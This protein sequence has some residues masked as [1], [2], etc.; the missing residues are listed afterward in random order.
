VPTTDK[1]A[2][3]LACANRYA[4]LDPEFHTVLGPGSGDYRTRGFMANVGFDVLHALR[5]LDGNTPWPVEAKICGNNSLAV[6]FYFQDQATIVEIALG[7]PNPA[8]EFEKDILK[9]LMARHLGHDV[10]RLVFISRPGAVKKCQQPGRIAMI[11]WAAQK[12]DL[13]IDVLELEGVERVRK[14]KSRKA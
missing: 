4:A 14:R 9:A 3:V 6:D 11:V 7:L 1:V 12:H 8:S 13:A 2:I 10:R 5:P